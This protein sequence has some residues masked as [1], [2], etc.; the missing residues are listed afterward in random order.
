MGSIVNEQVNSKYFTLWEVAKGAYA[1][2]E[3]K[4]ADTGSNA[5]FV[6]MGEYTVVFDAFLNT[7]AA[8]DLIAASEALTGRKPSIL[9]N[10]HYHADHVVGNCMF[11]KTARVITSGDVYEKMLTDIT[12]MMQEIQGY[13]PKVLEDIE[14]QISGE[15]NELKL[16]DLKND[17]K[18]LNNIMKPDV[19][20]RLPD[21]TFGK[22][23]TLHGETRQAELISVGTAHSPGDVILYLPDEKICFMGDLLFKHSHPWLGTGDPENFVKVLEELLRMDAEIFIPGHGELASKSDIELEIKYIKE[24]LALVETKK[25][26]GEAADTVTLQD[27]SPEFRDWDSLC[28][29]WNIDYFFKREEK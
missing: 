7:D 4:D 5:G 10:S 9:V 23:L 17:Y 19:Q 26:K 14:E 16:L 11:D 12:K 22:T 28:F 1:A 27:L 29:L 2:I 13:G 8:K 15:K 18:F 21:I 25:A 3:K 6:N 24:L 20:L